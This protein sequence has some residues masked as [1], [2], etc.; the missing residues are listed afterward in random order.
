MYLLRVL[1]LR[2]CKFY[3]NISGTGYYA[4]RTLRVMHYESLNIFPGNALVLM[5]AVLV[6]DS[7]DTIFLT[8]LVIHGDRWTPIALY[9][10]VVTR[11]VNPGDCGS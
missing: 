2:E 9:L 5:A 6:S 10:P 8:S 3:I 1:E 7:D 11:G 4:R